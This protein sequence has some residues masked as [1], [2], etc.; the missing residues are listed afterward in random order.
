ME[1]QVKRRTKILIVSI[2]CVLL[3]TAVYF[4]ITQKKKNVHHALYA[5]ADEKI[6]DVVVKKD[7]IQAV[8]DKKQHVSFKKDI[9]NNVA[10]RYISKNPKMVLWM[11]DTYIMIEEG[12]TVPYYDCSVGGPKA[13]ELT[14]PSIEI[15]S[16][17]VQLAPQVN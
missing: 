7:T 11:N 8:L 6:V 4:A 13:E 16:N 15:P 12:D 1:T 17:E 3:C 9:S 14:N 2:V 10:S 5:C